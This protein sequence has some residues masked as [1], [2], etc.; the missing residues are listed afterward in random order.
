MAEPG[1]LT[2]GVAPG[3]ELRTGERFG[4]LE[5]GGCDVIAR[6]HGL[7]VFGSDRSRRGAVG[8]DPV[9]VRLLFLIDV[10]SHERYCYRAY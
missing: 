9:L 2:L 8:E 1:V 5:E 10:Q 3:C 6:H 4:V 7:S